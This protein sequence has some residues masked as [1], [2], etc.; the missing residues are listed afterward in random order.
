MDLGGPFF[1]AVELGVPG[2]LQQS[3][4]VNPKQ[5]D[6][7]GMGLSIW[8]GNMEEHPGRIEVGNCC[9]RGNRFTAVLQ[10]DG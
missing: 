1:E 10:I 8:W 6:D 9:G 5:G 4:A 7:M 2:Y 3:T